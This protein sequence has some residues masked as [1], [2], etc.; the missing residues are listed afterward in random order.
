MYLPNEILERT[1]KD[2]PKADLKAARLVNSQWSSCA[3]RSLFDTLYISPHKINIDV[4][5]GVAQHPVLRHCVKQ[6]RYDAVGFSTMLDYR[7]YFLRLWDDTNKWARNLRGPYDSLDTQY[8]SFV[9]SARWKR[10]RESAIKRC[11]D[12]DRIKAGFIRWQE[13]AVFE[14]KCMENSNFVR[15]L[16]AGLQRVSRATFERIY[17]PRS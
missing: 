11:G 1:L 2:L 16:A 10:D 14:R 12:L 15:I 6:L 7:Q 13:H 5:Q 4:F 9:R 8:N 3:N 17:L